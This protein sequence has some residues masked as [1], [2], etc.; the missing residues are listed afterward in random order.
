MTVASLTTITNVSV[1]IVPILVNDIASSIASASSDI[2][3]NVSRQISIAPGADLTVETRRVDLG[4]LKELA[5]K[6]L[7]SYTTT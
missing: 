1:Q 2:A 5:Q 4:Q 3:A 6:R 7:I